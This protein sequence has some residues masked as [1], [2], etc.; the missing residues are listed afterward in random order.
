MLEAKFMSPPVRDAPRF[1]CGTHQAALKQFRSIDGSNGISHRE[2]RDFAENSQIIVAW[3]RGESRVQFHN[4]LPVVTMVRVHQAGLSNYSGN[5][6]IRQC[7]EVYSCEY[8]I[9]YGLIGSWLE[10]F[11]GVVDNPTLCIRHG[12]DRMF[13]ITRYLW[14]AHEHKKWDIRYDRQDH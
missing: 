1:D 5:S 3:R 9:P 2:F 12:S 14:R 4:I 10:G 8:L 11:M 7:V 13:N 6:I